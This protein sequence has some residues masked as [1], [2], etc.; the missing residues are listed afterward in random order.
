[1][2]NNGWIR[3]HRKIMEGKYWL[4]EPF[5]RAQ[6][7][8]DLL[9]LANHKTGTI[10]KRGILIEVQRGEVGYSEEALA[11]RWRWSRG[12]VRRFISELVS[13][14]SI[15]RNPVQQNI[16]LSSLIF[17]INYD[18]YQTDRTTNGTTNGTGTIRR[19][20]NN[21]YMSESDFNIF[22]QK[23]PKHEAKKKAFEAWKKIQP[24]NGLLNT[25]LSA[26]DKQKESENW[27]KDD[28][29]YI[30]LPATWLNGRRWEDE[31]PEA[32]KSSW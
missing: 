8:V 16:H 31:I 25:I 28:G 17:I 1:M 10:R 20:R 5:T 2:K 15:L 32:K 19:R 30:P 22:Y 13:E 29:K 27:K 4:S 11:R 14:R 18:C 23:Y 21:I 12:K 9:I 7:W 3:L 6:A 24:T 26:V